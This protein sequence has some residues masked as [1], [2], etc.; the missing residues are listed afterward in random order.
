M[1][2]DDSTLSQHK[3]LLSIVIIAIGVTLQCFGINSTVTFLTGAASGYFTSQM[4]AT[5][6]EGAK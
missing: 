1:T 2:F 5:P 3:L 6:K 4:F